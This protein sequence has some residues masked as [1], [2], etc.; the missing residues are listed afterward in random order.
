MQ[1]SAPRA[2]EQ[3]TRRVGR[4][5]DLT[6]KERA[7]A[8]WKKKEKKKGGSVFKC[9]VISAE[10]FGNCLRLASGVKST[11]ASHSSCS[12]RSDAAKK[13]KTHVGSRNLSDTLT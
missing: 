9:G 1:M 2:F 5:V 4:E 8:G 10:Y 6:E 11:P 3:A 7:R 12:T 13:K